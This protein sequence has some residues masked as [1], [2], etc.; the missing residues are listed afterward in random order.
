MFCHSLMF[1]QGFDCNASMYVVVYQQS[2]AK[3]TL[4]EIKEQ[5][6]RYSFSAINL[7]ED[8]QLT[9]LVYNVLDK[10]LLA[11]D[12]DTYELIRISKN[13]ELESLGVPDKIDQTMQ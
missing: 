8:R 4:F 9:A 1:S 3:S 11:L 6:G 5:N 7:S 13:G 12:A 10:H 2:L